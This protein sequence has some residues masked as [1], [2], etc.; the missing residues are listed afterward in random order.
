MIVAKLDGTYYMMSEA[1]QITGIPVSTLRKWTRM[2]NPPV[3]APSQ[4]V[5]S[6]QMKIY[7][8]TP[9]DIEE[10]KAYR[11]ATTTTSRKKHS[12]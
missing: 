10:L 6:G 8:F 7:L 9:D 11:K 4:E 5:I 2:D 12:K 1:S 3:N